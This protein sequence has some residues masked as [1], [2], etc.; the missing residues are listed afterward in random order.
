MSRFQRV[1]VYFLM[2]MF[3][4]FLTTGYASS[5]R[6]VPATE[7]IDNFGRVDEHLWRGAQPSLVGIENLKRLGVATIINL[8]MD[9]DVLPGEEETAK[10][11]GIH[12]EHVPFHGLRGPTSEQVARVLT[13][14]ENSPGP[15][16]VHCE[17]GAD[18]TGTIVACYRIRHD[19]W[20][21]EQ[22]LTE[23]KRYGMSKWVV[24]M[25]RY[26]L[27]FSPG[28]ATVK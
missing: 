16:F 13:L 17:H 20:T 7:G 24:G 12:Y 9:G 28:L 8:R 14:I 21:S 18:R 15:V 26:V 6:G 11:N 10:K 22:A 4:P 5:I 19:G 2:S 3:L 25:K 23:A 1:P 27:S